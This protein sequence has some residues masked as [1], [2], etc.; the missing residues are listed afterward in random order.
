MRF[1]IQKFQDSLLVLY[2]AILPKIRTKMEFWTATLNS[3]QVIN[4]NLVDFSM[5]FTYEDYSFVK[6]VVNLLMTSILTN[7]TF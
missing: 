6:N 3:F 2:F 5:Q 7:K 1:L 4:V